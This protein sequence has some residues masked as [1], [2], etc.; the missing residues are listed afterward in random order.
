MLPERKEKYL[1][2]LEAIR[3]LVQERID[4]LTGSGAVVDVTP[5]VVSAFTASGISMN[6]ATFTTTVNESSI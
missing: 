5:P 4:G 6:S 1:D 3:I 2:M